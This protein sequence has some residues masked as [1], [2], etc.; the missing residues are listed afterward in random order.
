MITHDRAL[1]VVRDPYALEDALRDLRSYEELALDTETYH[2]PTKPTTPYGFSDPFTNK[3]RLVQ[4][5]GATSPAYVIDLRHFSDEELLPLRTFLSDPEKLWVL[6]NAKFD[7]KMIKVDLGVTLCRIWDT[8]IASQLIGHA[9]G[10]QFGKARG[11]GLRSVLKDFLGIS[12]NKDEQVSYW[13]GQ[14]TDEQIRYAGNDVVHILALKNKL[15]AAL[16]APFPEGFDMAVATQD[17]MDLIPVLGDIE[18]TGVA[19]DVEMFK[20][21]QAAAKAAIP[22]LVERICKSFGIGIQRGFLGVSPAINLDSPQQLM[23][24]LRKNG[25]EVK[26]TEADVLEE[27][28]KL[29]PK[30]GDLLEYKKLK[31]AEKFP[32]S[33]WV[34]P[35][36]KR[37]HPSYNQLGAG[38]SRLSCLTGETL[39]ET[40]QGLRRMDT[41]REGDMVVTSYGPRRV[42]K[43]WMT[44]VKPVFKVTLSDGRTIR[45][46]DNHQFL[47]GLG[48]TWAELSTL[49]VGDPLYVTLKNTWGTHYRGHVPLDIDPGSRYCKKP[50][51]VPTEMSTEL[52][53]LA[54][55]FTADGWLGERRVR[56][57]KPGQTNTTQAQYDRIGLAFGWQDQETIDYLN[58][59]AKKLFGR[60]FEEIKG[61]TCRVLQ[62]ASTQAAGAFAKLGLSGNAHT[63]LVPEAILGGPLLYQAA[64][65][66][67][68][69]EGDGTAEKT[70]V[71]LTSVNQELLRQIQL[72]LGNLGIYA[73]IDERKGEQTGFSG[74]ARADLRV[75]GKAN[76]QRF[77]TR[78]GFLS[79]RKTSLVDIKA[80]P[81]DGITT[82][83]V[84]DGK[85]L[86]RE[87]VAAGTTPASREGIAPF[88]T[89]YKGDR[90]TDTKAR[91]LMDRF[92]ELPSLQPIK[93]YLERE[94]RAVEIVSIEPDGVEPVYDITV[95]GVHEFVANGLVVHNCNDP[96]LQQVPK[97]MLKIPD[98][99]FD[100]VKH[101]K[102]RDKKASDK[103]GKDIYTVSYRCC[104]VAR[105]GYA[106]I[107][108][109]FSG[110]ELCIVAAMSE[111]TRMCHILS[112]PEKLP[113]GSKNPDSDLH[114][115]AANGMFPQYSVADIA[116][117]CTNEKGE[118][119]R[120]FGK[121][122]NFATIYGKTK[123][124]YAKDWN[125][126]TREADKILKGYFATFPGLK[127]WLDRVT[128]IGEATR[129]SRFPEGFP[130]DRLRFLNDNGKDDAGAVGRASKNTPV[131]GCGAIMV[132]KSLVRLHRETAGTDCR[133][134]LTV[135]DE[136]G[137][138]APTATAQEWGIKI[139]ASMETVAN[140]FLKGLVPGRAEVKIGATWHETH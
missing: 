30:L 138:E 16:I 64:Y 93:Q 54:G 27:A 12:V 98:K 60:S 106:F 32:Y 80:G 50:V 26:S 101:A 70:S 55:F 10:T 129:L 119:I 68:L 76:V 95:E 116:N 35:V 5:K 92:G 71:K 128:E 135:H 23:E 140:Y 137:F 36:T 20:L 82:P 124:G 45:A 56:P 72:M 37:L 81:K 24:M 113:D 91:R 126:S 59:H 139:R 48:D 15:Q 117:G 120:D 13:G 61:G 79:N 111:D 109:D 65:L 21:V 105:E 84:A 99:L 83:F 131:Q 78:V 41:L 49:K 8:M 104:F 34:H 47:T 132:K 86:Y 108:S 69:F 100:P 19:F 1:T 62:L 46:T 122:I 75:T 14:L 67:G 102:Y 88:L 39:I 90:L 118:K 63:K 17:E 107:D 40:T 77:M 130:E 66:R 29:Y 52:A 7:Y 136:I 87:A 134:T 97:L 110:Q 127:A 96:N 31:R 3:V 57:V 112:Q 121:V 114:S 133:L 6:H 125:I 9:C 22:T 103:A 89:H 2:D 42:E 38:T 73:V 28:A 11:H 74:T 115:I 123:E 85:T 94:L 33:D 18:L 4:L 51:T 25:I 44:G 58:L 43:A 53:E